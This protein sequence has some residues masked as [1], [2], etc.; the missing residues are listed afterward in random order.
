M[1]LCREAGIIFYGNLLRSLNR[2][3]RG[4]VNLL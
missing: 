1:M 4:N 2:E 3:G